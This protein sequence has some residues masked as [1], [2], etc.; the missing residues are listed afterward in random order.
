MIYLDASALV[1]LIRRESET[2]ALF[3]W[4]GDHASVVRVSSCLAEIEVA[5]AIQ[6][7]D[8]VA[9]A[10]IPGVMARVYRIE[11]DARIRAIAVAHEDML[12]RSLDAIHLAT[13]EMLALVFEGEA[14]DAFVAYDERLLAA[15]QGRGLAVASPGT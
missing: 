11:I 3:A 13:A 2:P 5:R 1:K 7:Y 8:P 15:A 14:L 10:R 9:L 6:R 4:L 12:L